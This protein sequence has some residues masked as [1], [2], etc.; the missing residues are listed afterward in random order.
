MIAW[1]EVPANR[2]KIRRTTRKTDIEMKLTTSGK[3]W[4]EFAEYMNEETTGFA[5]FTESSIKARYYRLV[6]IYRVVKEKY[7]R[8]GGLTEQD[9][10][11]G[12]ETINDK[13]VS[14]VHGYHRIDAIF[15][16]KPNVTP[17]SQNDS[18]K[19][20]SSN[21]DNSEKGRHQDESDDEEEYDAAPVSG[22]VGN[23][24]QRDKWLSFGSSMIL[25]MNQRSEVDRENNERRMEVDLQI[26]RM[27]LK[28]EENRRQADLELARVKAKAEVEKDFNHRIMATM[29]KFMSEG[30]SSQEFEDFIKVLRNNTR[31]PR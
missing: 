31:Q 9:I 10:M 28:Q 3:G 13:L 15:G 2:L 8:T 17:L 30:K 7:A 23:D 22:N 6:K 24:G 4:Q 18:T 16:M 27:K 29:E 21:V 19:C 1:L 12:F 26:A 14:L 11:D 5:T 20:D 25:A